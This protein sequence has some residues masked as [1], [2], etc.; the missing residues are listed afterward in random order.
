M[1]VRDR[2]VET[3]PDVGHHTVVMPLAALALAGYAAMRE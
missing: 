2:H 1:S 3:Q